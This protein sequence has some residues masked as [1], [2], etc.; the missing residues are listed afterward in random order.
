MFEKHVCR[1][2]IYIFINSKRLLTAENSTGAND[3]DLK[4]N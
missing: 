1:K 4:K 2:N 3:S